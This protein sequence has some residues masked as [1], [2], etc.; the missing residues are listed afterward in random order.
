[1]KVTVQIEFNGKTETVCVEVNRPD[2]F[3]FNEFE[4]TVRNRIFVAALEECCL[5]QTEGAKRLHV[6]RGRFGK[7]IREERDTPYILNGRVTKL[8]TDNEM[9]LITQSDIASTYDLTGVL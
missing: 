8:V 9:K 6:N 2:S 4:A 3:D 7:C 5:N 1:M